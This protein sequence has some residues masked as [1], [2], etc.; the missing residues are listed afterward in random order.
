MFVSLQLSHMGFINIYRLF[1]AAA[2]FCKGEKID[3]ETIQKLGV[4][5][6]SPVTHC[7]PPCQ[8]YVYKPEVWTSFKKAIGDCVK[9]DKKK[10]HQH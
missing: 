4:E 1:A 9:N 6:T 5:I 2:G 10:R 8:P 7:R 3:D